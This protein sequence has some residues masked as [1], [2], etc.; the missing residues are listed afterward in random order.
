MAGRRDEPAV[1][2]VIWVTA[3]P[4]RALGYLDA[5]ED[6]VVGAVIVVSKVVPRGAEGAVVRGGGRRVHLNSP[7]MA[8]PDERNGET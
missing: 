2:K 6:R 7:V 1:T 3:G 8:P 5:P 4:V